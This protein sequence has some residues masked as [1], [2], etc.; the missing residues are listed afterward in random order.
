MEPQPERLLTLV[1]YHTKVAPE[2]LRPS[3]GSDISH[4]LSERK[5]LYPHAMNLRQTT[6]TTLKYTVS[7]DQKPPTP[8]YQLRADHLPPNVNTSAL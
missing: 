7:G 2:G 1:V 4:V 3:E 8:P 5:N 6:V